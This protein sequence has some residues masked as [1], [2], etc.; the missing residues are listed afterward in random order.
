MLRRWISATDA[1]PMPTRTTRARM[2]PAISS[3]WIFVSIFESFTARMSFVSGVTRHAAATTG[4]ARAA[5]PTSSTPTTRVSPLSQSSFSERSVG[6]GQ[7]CHGRS[8]GT[9]SRALGAALLSQRCRLAHAVAEEVERRAARVPVARD[10]DLLDAG[11]V[12]QEG[13]LDADARRDATDGDLPVEAAVTDAQDRPLELLETFAVA[14][15]D[16]HAHG[17]GVTRPDVGDFGLLLLGGKRLQDVVHR[18]GDSAHEGD[19]SNRTAERRTAS[20][21]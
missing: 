2:S 1:A 8:C 13:A 21:P 11:R 18:H 5:M 3:G 17:N 19:N 4:P 14:L 7:E 6:I 12:Q 16:A 9:R 20:R 15:D 10:L